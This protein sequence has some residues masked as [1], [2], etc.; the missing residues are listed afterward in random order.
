MKKIKIGIG[1][2][3]I[4]L[5]LATIAKHFRRN[6]FTEVELRFNLNYFLSSEVDFLDHSMP[7]FSKLR[8][9]TLIDVHS[10][11]IFEQFLTRLLY[12]SFLEILQL[13]GVSIDGRWLQNMKRLSELYIDSP[14]CIK[15]D[16]LASCFT[17]NLQT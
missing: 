9:L 7:F 1:A 2:Y 5:L 17:V 8:K 3:S 10:S 12:V 6:R 11:G 14:K 13:Q 15:M 16:V 4:D